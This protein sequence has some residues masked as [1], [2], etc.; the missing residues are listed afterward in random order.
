M[1]LFENDLINELKNMILKQNEILEKINLEPKKRVKKEPKRNL[2]ID[3][4]I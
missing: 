2:K 3:Y 4:L 1:P